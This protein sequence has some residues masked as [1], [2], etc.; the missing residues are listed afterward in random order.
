[1][2]CA[3]PYCLQSTLYFC[4]AFFFLNFVYTYLKSKI[5]SRENKFI[6]FVTSVLSKIGI[7]LWPLFFIYFIYDIKIIEYIIENNTKI[8]FKK[9]Y[10][11]PK[12]IKFQ[13][14]GENTI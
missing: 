13:S 6:A 10:T 8:N 9:I 2:Y 4:A 7:I 3:L 14:Q 1:M 12:N 5:S 11:N